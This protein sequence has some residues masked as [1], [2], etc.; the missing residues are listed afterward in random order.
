MDSPSLSIRSTASKRE[1]VFSQ[2]QDE[3]FHVELKGFEVSASTDVW[4]YTD[5]AGLNNLFQELG[6]LDKPWQ[7][8]RS[9]GAIE[10]DFSLSATC[11]SLGSV[12]FR[13]K[14]RGAQG[15]P[16]EWE[17]SAGLVIEFGQLEQIARSSNAFFCT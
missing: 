13:V 11:T 7:G 16:E 6:S 17:V 8:D 9:W 10:G 4:A 15:A 2:R 1:L 3:R 12:T 14:I 5:A